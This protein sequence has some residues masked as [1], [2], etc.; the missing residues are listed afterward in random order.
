MTLHR[1]YAPRRSYATKY[2]AGIRTRWPGFICRPAR[3]QTPGLIIRI[4]VVIPRKASLRSSPLVP[5]A[6]IDYRVH[7]RSCAASSARSDSHLHLASFHHYRFVPSFFTAR[8]LRP[9]SRPDLPLVVSRGNYVAARETG[10][11]A[12]SVFSFYYPQSLC[13]CCSSNG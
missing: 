9:G 13:F 8:N 12:W 4:I 5:I 10:E 1:L 2:T 7:L 6:R 11:F 3:P